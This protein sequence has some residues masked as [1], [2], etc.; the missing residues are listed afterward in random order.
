MAIRRVAE[1][2]EAKLLAVGAQSA[3]GKIECKTYE[4]GKRALR[5]RIRELN[6][7]SSDYPLR[8]FVNDIAVGELKRTRNKAELEL[9]SRE[10]DPIPT[11][12]ADD[13][14]QIRSGELILAQGSFYED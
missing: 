6:D 14:A 3:S 8:L 5:A 2:H 10:G 12:V 7:V 4:D 11:I 13:Q 1:E 9:D